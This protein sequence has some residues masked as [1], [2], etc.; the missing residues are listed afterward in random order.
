MGIRL[1]PWTTPG[2][3]HI[4]SSPGVDA[5]PSIP[6]K[7]IPA[8]ELDRLCNE[9]RAEVFRKAGKKDPREGR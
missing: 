6:L 9:F 5:K 1:R 4:E 7:D 8:E 3:G 2:F